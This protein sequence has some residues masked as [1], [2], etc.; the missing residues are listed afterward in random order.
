MNITDVK[1]AIKAG[2]FHLRTDG[3]PNFISFEPCIDKQTYKSNHGRVYIL[4]SNGIIK[5]IGGSK[6]KGGLKNTIA[7]YTHSMQGNPGPP[8]YIIHLLIRDELQKGNNV[9]CYLIDSEPVESPIP[10][11]FDSN[12]KQFVTS[13]SE[14]ERRCLE[15]Y[16]KFCGEFPEWNFQESNTPYPVGYWKQFSD[17]KIKPKTKVS[18]KGK[19]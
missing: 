7:F 11:L 2:D 16:K 10:G 12:E 6:C 8:R 14:S 3:N 4:T 18:R 1:T 15:D 5:K 9:E 17:S 13:F 19:K